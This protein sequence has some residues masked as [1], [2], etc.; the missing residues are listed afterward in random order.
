MKDL[1]KI[2]VSKVCNMRSYEDPPNFGSFLGAMVKNVEDLPREKIVY[3]ALNYFKNWTEE[4]FDT[5]IQ[6]LH[7]LGISQVNIWCN[8]V[9]RVW[10]KG[11]QN[12]LVESL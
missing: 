6:L 7:S 8:T 9:P 3:G 1:G 12:F 10:E 11:L 2:N 5:R 4:E